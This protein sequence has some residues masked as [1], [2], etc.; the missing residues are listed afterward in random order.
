MATLRNMARQRRYR[1]LAVVVVLAALLWSGPGQAHVKAALLIAE[2]FPEAPVKPLEFLTDAPRHTQLTLRSASGPIAADMFQPRPRFGVAGRHA[3]PAII[4][5][6]GVK[7]K[8]GDRNMLLGLA[9]TLSRLG[10]VVLWPRLRALDHGSD[11]AEQPSTFITAID[12]LKGLDVVAP[13]RISILG[14]SVGSS[15]GFVA[16]TDPRVRSSV[17]GLVFFGGYYD[18]FDFLISLATHTSRFE[19]KTVAWQPDHEATSYVKKLLRSQRAWGVLRIFGTHTRAQAI[20]ILRA[21]PASELATLRAVNPSDHLRAFGTHIFILHDRGDH[22]VPYLEAAK[23]NQALRPAVARTYLISDLF[24]HTH[25][26]G[27]LS[28]DAVGGAMDL[29]GFLHAA[30]SYL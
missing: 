1:V 12:Y 20:T 11:Q 10:Y 30:L 13:H 29:Y 22:F 21:A 28:W 24:Q 3:Q 5:A 18:V 19:G 4:L 8:V 27:G 25:P 2:V 23:L 16:A 15:L 17:H 26:K 7:T 9:A 6:M 14:F